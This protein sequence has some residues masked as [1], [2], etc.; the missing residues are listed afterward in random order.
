MRQAIELA[1]PTIE[2]FDIRELLVDTASVMKH[3]HLGGFGEASS[4]ILLA[5]WL[6][7]PI[8]MRLKP[9]VRSSWIIM[10]TLA[11]EIN[12]WRA[13]LQASLQ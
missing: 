10:I 4:S 2:Q 1:P 12:Q 7:D 13:T 5:Q 8:P 6:M 3:A 11:N 9:S